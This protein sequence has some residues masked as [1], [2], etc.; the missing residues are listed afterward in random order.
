VSIYRYIDRRAGHVPVR[1]LCQV[2][3]M[4]PAAYYTWQRRQQMPTAEPAWQVAVGEVF[5]YHSQRYGTRRLRAEVQAQSHA[6]G[7]WRIWRV[8]KAHGLRALRVRPS[9]PARLCRA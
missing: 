6:V 8:L 3:R 4:G 9:S 7:R 5:A 2:L 1:Q